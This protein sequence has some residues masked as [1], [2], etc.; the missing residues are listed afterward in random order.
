MLHQMSRQANINAAL[1]E[2]D[3]T[4]ELGDILDPVDVS[5][6]AAPYQLKP[7]ELVHILAK[8]PRLLN[9]EYIALLQYLQHTGRPYQSHDDFPHPPNAL[10][11]HLGAQHPLQL[12]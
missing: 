5:A 7:S 1:H 6:D 3:S 2:T 4:R 12:N 8:A 9:T 11:L 10:V